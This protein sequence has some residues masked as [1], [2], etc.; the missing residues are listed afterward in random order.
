MNAV[1][2]N[3]R[4][5]SAAEV[6]GPGLVIVVG[7]IAIFGV[8]PIAEPGVY[9]IGLVFGMLGALTALGMA[10]IYR[11]NRILNFAQGELGL[12]PSV[13]ALGLITF[14]AMPY[15][16]ALLFGLG[17]AVLLGVVVEFVIIRRFAKASPSS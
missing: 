13:A 14:S 11:S 9:V 2:A 1:L 7:T 12:A 15:V 8:N 3:P 6:F 17:A 10:L 16:F 5:R 4:V